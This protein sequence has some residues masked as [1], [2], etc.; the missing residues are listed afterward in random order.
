MWR[1]LGKYTIDLGIYHDKVKPI[2]LA[3]YKKMDKFEA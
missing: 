3:E 2:F 1:L